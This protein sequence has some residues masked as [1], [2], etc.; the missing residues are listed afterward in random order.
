MKKDEIAKDVSAFANS[1]GG[2]VVYGIAESAGKP[3]YAEAL[4][5]VDPKKYS[6]EWLEQVI[7]TRRFSY[8]VDGAF[9]WTGETA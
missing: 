6:Q 4:S 2:T 7:N 3:S 5:P 9:S 8:T 1:A